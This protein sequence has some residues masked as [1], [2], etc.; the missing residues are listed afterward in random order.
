MSFITTFFDL[1]LPPRATD[2]LVRGL[3]LSELERLAN[4]E[5][6]MLPYHDPRI[7]A[8][9]WELKYQAH[10]RALMLAGEFLS[11]QLLAIAGEE[12]G[13]PLLIPVP[14]H[15]ARHRARGHNQT[16]LL[17]KASL[18][19]ASEFVEYR[20]DVLVRT[21]DTVPQQ[22]LERAKRLMNVK[23]SM[24]VSKPDAVIGRICVV[25]D[26]VTTTGATL[27]EA[28]RALVAAGAA[29]VHLVALAQS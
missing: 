24:E 9:I 29:R 3:T 2:R 11:N 8:L 19:H 18:A 4:Q 27:E 28:R 7:T 5:S 10:A 13:K 6:G 20:P 22:G 16:E 14:M 12:L 23:G 1:L 21:K 17:C 26:D 25:V 15:K